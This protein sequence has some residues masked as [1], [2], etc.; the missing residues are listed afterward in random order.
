ML[1]LYNT[2][3]REKQPFK[4]QDSQRITLYVCGP[5]VYNHAHIGNAR[6]VVVFDTL[7]RLLQHYYGAAQVVYARNI[8]DVDD[9]ILQA[10]QET[11]LS[12]QALTQ[13][14]TQIF[15]EDIAALN[16]L[17]PTHEPRATDNI[18]GMIELIEQLLANKM[19]YQA[20]SHVLFDTEAFAAYGKLSG[21][22]DNSA[23][24]AGVRVEVESYKKIRAILCYG[25]PLIKQC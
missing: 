6:P 20:D 5:T 8:T 1:T 10:A 16:T 19:A 4:P 3:A 24:Q 13:K 23:R 25:N 22:E 2:A 9:K 14:Y 11:G 21:R 17:P 12:P 7:F 15:H 18:P